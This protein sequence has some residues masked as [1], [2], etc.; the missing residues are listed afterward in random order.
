MAGVDRYDTSTKVAQSAFPSGASVVLV[1]NGTLAHFPDALAASY[2]GGYLKAPVILTDGASLATTATQLLQSL[3]PKAI[4]VIGGTSA[5]AGSVLSQL[6]A[7]GFTAYRVGGATRYD[8]AAAVAAVP[9]KS[10]VGTSGLPGGT[11][12]VPTAVLASGANF[13]D[14]L[15]S[16]PM[17]YASAFPVEITDP[18]G[19][20]AQT[21]QSLQALGIRRVLIAGGTAAV[22]AA[23]E[24]QVTALG[25]VTQR[26]AGADR[27]DT[28]AQIATYE[29]QSLGYAST[30]VGLAR[31]D[32]PA[33]SLSGGPLGGVF[34][35]PILLTANP[36]TLGTY[37]AAWLTS[38]ASTLASGVIFGGL[39]AV[40][41]Q[42]QDQATAAARGSAGTVSITASPQTL[43]TTPGSTSALTVTVVHADG[44][45]QANDPVTITTSGS[46]AAA[47][48]IV[49]PV[50]GTTNSS[51]QLTATYTGSLTAGTCTIT[52]TEQTGGASGS[53]VVTEGSSSSGYAISLVSSPPSPANLTVAPSTN[54]TATLTAT[55]T[56][57][58]SQ[59]V[60]DQVT[61][62]TSGTCGTL[63]PSVPTLTGPAGTVTVVYTASTTAGTCTITATESTG[64]K[65]SGPVTINQTASGGGG[66]GSGYAIAL[67]SPASP[68]N[69]SVSPS[70]N[71]TATVTAAVANGGNPAV[72]DLVTF[73]PTGHCGTLLPLGPVPT[74]ATGTV[75]A[76]YTASTSAGTCTITATEMTGGKTSTAVTINQT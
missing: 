10:Y 56:N 47:C 49:V 55:V 23:V 57:G 51:G 12:G 40:S 64:N 69:L 73:S 74:G 70:L 19:L 33:D 9:P 46:P 50:A 25:I 75:S 34:K 62:G 45:P 4:G 60:G 66:G 28:A 5:V 18:A 31:G 36:T 3:H 21:Q 72:G 44:T 71:S 26:F 61:F 6:G 65:T 38:H 22:P 39:A 58:P 17:G 2:L 14:A 24:S 20:S 52:A 42:V 7:L 53:V 35:T 13:P 11:V 30:G 8:T 41:Q 59:A 68:A 32:D 29:L 37:S 63:V 76:I 43:P 15:V 67:T 48:G 16:G 1:A 27:T 54:S